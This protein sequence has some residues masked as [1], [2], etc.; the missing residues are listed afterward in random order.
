[1][2]SA[3]VP[4]TWPACCNVPPDHVT[5]TLLRVDG[6]TTEE[7][8]ARVGRA[9]RAVKRKLGLIRGIWRIKQPRPEG[10]TPAPPAAPMAPAAPTETAVVS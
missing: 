6:H 4:V 7:I 5:V 3:N 10:S 8:A 1:M 2:T 9:P